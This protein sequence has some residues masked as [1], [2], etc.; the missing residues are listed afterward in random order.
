MLLLNNISADIKLNK[1]QLSKVIQWG[2]FLGKVL[3]NTMGNLGLKE[4]AVPLT[5]DVLPKLATKATSSR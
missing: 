3:S 1:S 2:G 4:L 5:K